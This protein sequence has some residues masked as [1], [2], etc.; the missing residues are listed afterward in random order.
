MLN[1]LVNIG[2]IKVLAIT[3]GPQGVGLLSQLNN[4]F[5]VLS[6][7]TS[8]GLNVGVTRNI[9]EYSAASR[10]KSILD[11]IS[12]VTL[13]LSG[14]LAVSVVIGIIF[15][16]HIAHLI[17]DNRRYYYFIIITL[18]GLP[19]IVFY[20]F[21]RSIFTGLLEIKTYVLVGVLSAVLGLIALVPFVLLYKLQGAVWHLLFYSA[22][23]FG[24]A[25]YF[26]GKLR[27][28]HFAEYGRMLHIDRPIIKG[29][30]KIGATS[31]IAGTF[32]SLSLLLLRSLIIGSLGLKS[33]GVFAA[34]L[35]MSGQSIIV[36]TDSIG[37]YALPN[38][39]SLTSN[40]D[41]HDELNQILR[42]AVVLSTP[43]ILAFFMLKELVITLFYSAEFLEATKLMGFQLF[44]EFFKAVGWS[45]G[46][47][48][49]PLKRL[50]AIV[51]IDV[52]WSMLY[53]GISYFTLHRF[54]LLGAVVAYLICYVLHVAA[55]YFYLK[56]IINFSIWAQN[57]KL[58]AVSVTLLGFVIFFLR[59][60]WGYY[61]I[62][63]LL[64][65]LWVK[66]AIRKTEIMMAW[67]KTK[68]FFAKT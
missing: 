55:N 58:L 22:G 42:L 9:A 17:L 29:L 21:I 33:A 59:P 5:Q 15:S 50:K 3:L 39:S 31:L 68:T 23:S 10:K 48:L 60:H 28:R 8:L 36:I 30:L 53:I 40:K 64:T 46:I 27:N 25:V 14:V 52:A 43:V 2:K 54:G 11:L 62:A 35:A 57:Q 37:T 12:T 38:L 56:K 51:A 63:A 66:I 1:T 49:L 65:G 20:N 6:I 13:V 61:L 26:F 4:F 45:M 34:V 32:T 67:E 7:A 24:L 16:S 47:A 41:F 44:G 18:T 19:F